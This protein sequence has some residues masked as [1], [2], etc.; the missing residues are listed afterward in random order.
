VLIKFSTFLVC[1]AKLANT[2]CWKKHETHCSRGSKSEQ[3][4]RCW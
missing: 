2:S 4:G 1:P 3:Q